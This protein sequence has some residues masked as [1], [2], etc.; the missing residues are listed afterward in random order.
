MAQEPLDY[1]SRTHPPTSPRRRTFDE[2]MNI[3]CGS[4][5]GLIVLLV[6]IAIIRMFLEKSWF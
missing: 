2:K 4:V 1:E 6:L 5:L 3:G